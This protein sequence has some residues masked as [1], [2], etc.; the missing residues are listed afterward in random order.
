[1]KIITG[2]NIRL[3]FEEK[4]KEKGNHICKRI[5][6]VI[7][8]FLF[9]PF[10]SERDRTDVSKNVKL[11]CKYCLIQHK[12][13]IEKNNETNKEMEDNEVNIY[14]SISVKYK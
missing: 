9:V 2:V 8:F 14:V 11:D 5:K 12:D 10:E 3:E 1:M 6:R 13:E 7:F 4:I